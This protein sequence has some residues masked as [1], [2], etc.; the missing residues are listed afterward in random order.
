MMAV[1]GHDSTVYIWSE[2]IVFK[3]KHLCPNQNDRKK[4]S[5]Y[6]GYSLFFVLAA[7]QIFNIMVIIGI[8]INLRTSKLVQRSK[9]QTHE[10]WDCQ[11]GKQKDQLH[12]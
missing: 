10:I 3:L 2:V 12:E 9:L 7:M 8:L 4:K 11:G 5:S 1:K 6:S